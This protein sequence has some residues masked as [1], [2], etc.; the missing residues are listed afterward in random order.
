MHRGTL[1]RMTQSTGAGEPEGSRRHD[2]EEPPANRLCELRM[3]RGWTQQEV[4]DRIIRRSRDPHTSVTADTVSKW[5]RGARGISARY[6]ALLAGIFGVSIDQLGL[7]GLARG[8]TQPHREGSLVAMVDQAAELLDQLGDAGHAIRPQ[9]LAALT[10]E[11]LSRRAMLTFIDTPEPAPTAPS[12]DE[13]DTLA[14]RYEAAH[15]TA[16]PAALLT[17]LTAHLRMVADALDRDPS[18][19]SRQRLLRNRARIS[20]LAG[21]VSEDLSNAM[22]ARAYYAQATDDG[23]EL[24][25][26]PVAAI[27]HGYA[28]R[29]ALTEGQAAAALR[30]LDAAGRLDISDPVIV[31]WLSG[32]VADAHGPR[33]DGPMGQP[34]DEPQRRAPGRTTTP[35]A[36]T[37]FTGQPSSTAADTP[38]LTGPTTS[39][40]SAGRGDLTLTGPSR[41]ARQPAA[42]ARLAG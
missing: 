21:Q 4:A 16:T 25:D 26:L 36:V 10:D 39:A 32:I 27:A 6:R 35:A 40:R 11:V 28:A 15:R 20:V 31:S 41:A 8:T 17:A 13:L 5:E 7:P 42:G 23:Y 14:S 2:R 1:T 3:E 33:R 12:P 22:A 24:G 29:L 19:G 9:V 37:W 30:H 18:A 38:D 34:A